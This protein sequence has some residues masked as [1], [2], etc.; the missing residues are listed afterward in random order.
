MSLPG[1]YILPT[2][3]LVRRRDIGSWVTHLLLLLSFQNTHTHIHAYFESLMQQTWV[4]CFQGKIW[5]FGAQMEEGRWFC[6]SPDPRMWTEIPLQHF[7]KMSSEQHL[8]CSLSWRE[9]LISAFPSAV[10]E[11]VELIDVRCLVDW[12]FTPGFFLSSLALQCSALQHRN[13][14]ILFIYLLFSL[15]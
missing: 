1:K 11:I 5:S 15:W 2:V 4:I 9:G 12:V 3:L 14:Q 8:Q 7:T 6:Y 13:T 10:C